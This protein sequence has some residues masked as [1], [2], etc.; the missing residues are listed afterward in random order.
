MCFCPSHLAGFGVRG[1]LPQLMA[2]IN[3]GASGREA[4]LDCKRGGG[5]GALCSGH[6]QLA[7]SLTNVVC[8]IEP[9][10]SRLER[11]RLPLFVFFH[12]SDGQSA[13][14]RQQRS[15]MCA[16]SLSLQHVMGHLCD[17][18]GKCS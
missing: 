6:Q 1:R 5:N 13:S 8:S 16:L 11:S 10:Q 4:R 15:L 7:A 3:P 2:D 18:E 12:V 17:R 9:W 14:Y